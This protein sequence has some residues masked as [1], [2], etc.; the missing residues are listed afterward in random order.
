MVHHE[1]RFLHHNFVVALLND[2]FGIQARGGCSCA[3][4]YGHRLLGIDLDQS[5]EFERE[6]DRGCEG[7]KPGW[8]RVNVNYFIDEPTFAYLLEA[9]HL[10]ATDGWRLLPWYRFEP[11]TGLWRH[12]DGP[13]DPPRSLGDITYED[14]SVSWPHP[15][16]VSPDPSFERYLD[17][18]R[19]VLTPAATRPEPLPA[20]EVTDDFGHLR[21]FWFPE[22]VPA[23]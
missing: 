9:V 13:V 11:D 5:H 17:E 4:P 18:A 10:V 7:I 1:D 19:A 21:W 14:G 23:P 2:L 8:T 12:R 3:G 15:D 20:P 16:R 22:D 6:V